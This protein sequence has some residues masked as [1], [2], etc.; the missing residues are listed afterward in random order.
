MKRT[1]SGMPIF[2]KNIIS[3][4]EASFDED[5]GEYMTESKIEVINFDKVKEMY[6]REAKFK[7]T[8]TPASSDA[9]YIGRD[10]EYT[11]VEFKNG[12]IK[13]TTQ[14]EVHYKIYDS[15]LMLGVFINQNIDFHR[16][17][18]RFILVYNEGKNRREASRSKAKIGGHIANKA[19][20]EIIEFDLERFQKYC[21]K[22][23][24]TYTEQEFQ[25][26]F[27]SKC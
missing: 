14:Y 18:V 27:L 10:G 5:N 9:L 13:S 23:V 21:F 24:S 15:L 11:L 3:F 4:K 20:K 17:N 26:K 25:D 22:Q 1:Y 8:N 12:L 2:D 16:E 7:S 6:V 19:G